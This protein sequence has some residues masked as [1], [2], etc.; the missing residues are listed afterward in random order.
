MATIGMTKSATGIGALD[1]ILD[2]GLPQNASIVISGAPGTGKTLFSQQWLFSGLKQFKEKGLYIGFTESIA[3]SLTNLEGL[4]FYEKKLVGTHGVEFVDFRNILEKL[5]YKPNEPLPSEDLDQLVDVIRHIADNM[6]AKRIVLDSF[7]ALLSLIKSETA[8][9]DFIFRLGTSIGQIDATIILIVES[10]TNQDVYGIETFV[11]DGLIKF[12]YTI[13][14]QQMIRQLNVLK[15]RG[16]SFRSG[17]VIFDINADGVLIYP[18]IPSYS[19][20]AKTDFKRRVSFGIDKMDD[21][22]GGGI[23]QGHIMLIGGNTGSGKSTFGL[24]FVAAGLKNDEAT[25]FVALEE[26]VT[27]V[28]KTAKQHG[29]NFDKLEKDGKLVF[30][31]AELLDIYPDKLLY[32][33]VNSIEKCN[34]RRLIIDSISSMENAA[35]D[36]DRVRQFLLQ[37]IAYLKKEGITCVMTYLTTELFGAS[38]GQLMSGTASTELGLSSMVD[39]ILLL[40]YVEREQQVKKLLTILKLRGSTHEKGIIEF[41]I[42]KGGVVIGDKFKE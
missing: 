13:G 10:R 8:T 39:A 37:L 36:R 12:N 28:K 7:T 29:F 26:S 38:S 4:G 18:K 2:G 15:M 17:P 40:R 42:N 32:D 19:T 41:A 16:T 5:A 9:R 35:F 21:L 34:A 22:L 20:T 3:K 23:P 31:T 6:G 1:E 25:C 11:A 30:V 33:I 27:Q 24:E 14:Q